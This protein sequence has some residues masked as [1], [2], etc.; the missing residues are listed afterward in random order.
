[1]HYLP[2]TL[3]MHVFKR[4]LSKVT[5]EINVKNTNNKQQHQTKL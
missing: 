3:V 4:M 5:Y 1:M 2:Y